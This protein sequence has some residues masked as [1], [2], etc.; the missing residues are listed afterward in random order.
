[1]PFAQIVKVFTT[2]VHKL[3]WTF[4]TVGSVLALAYVMNLS[5]QTLTIGKWIAGV[6]T[7]FAF[8]CPI[9]GWIGTAV[10]GS[11]TST[12]ALFSSLQ[13]TAAQGVGVDPRLLIGA[14]TAGGAVGK[15]ISP[16]TLAIAASAVGGKESDMLRKAM[17]WSVALL[18]VLCLIVG[19]ESTAI[20]GWILPK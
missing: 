9:L 3:R 15:M 2:Q 6:G 17:P 13:Q 19:L 16:Q 20:L 11:G 7:L 14:N 12:T 5:G 10:T 18:V 1:M 4:V 8:F